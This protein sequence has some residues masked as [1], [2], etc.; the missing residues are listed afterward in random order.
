MID[1]IIFDDA[2]YLF[3]DTFKEHPSFEADLIRTFKQ[4]VASNRDNVPDIFGR[5]VPYREPK[6]L[7]ELDV[8]HIHLKLPP[9]R[10]PK[11]LAQ[12]YRCNS[13]KRPNK[14]IFLVYVQ[15]QYNPE[16]FAL[17][18]ILRPNAH[19]KSKQRRILKLLCEMAEKYQE[20]EFELYCTN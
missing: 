20:N 1:V 11:K 16:R 7:Y 9:E 2:R 15:S 12:Y 18:S 13:P 6:R 14:D 10:F 3:D 17:L 5:D 4:Y 19:K 8:H